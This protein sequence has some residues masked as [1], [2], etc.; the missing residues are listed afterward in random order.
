MN[1]K[2]ALV[3]LVSFMLIAA[4]VYLLASTVLYGQKLVKE[5]YEEYCFVHPTNTSFQDALAKADRVIIVLEKN[6]DDRQGFKYVSDQL[7][8]TL[9]PGLNRKK[10]LVDVNSIY[11]REYANGTLI[12]CAG[13]NVTSENCSIPEPSEKELMIIIRPPGALANQAVL[14]GNKIIFEGRQGSDI[15]LLMYLFDRYYLQG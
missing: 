2:R 11:G 3:L 6:A 4:S 9:I 14:Q 13:P 8:S 10:Q 15:A 7:A 1:W 5:C 12:N